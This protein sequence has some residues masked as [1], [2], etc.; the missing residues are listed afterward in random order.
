MSMT[1]DA[2]TPTATEPSLHALRVAAVLGLVA[3]VMVVL[4]G[5]SVSLS[6]GVFAL[7]AAPVVPLA[8]V[9]VTDRIRRR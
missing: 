2:K 6:Y 3:A 5:F 8:F 7:I 9:I 1:Q 4:I